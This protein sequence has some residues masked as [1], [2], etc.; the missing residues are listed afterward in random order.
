MGDFEKAVKGTPDIK[1]GF[2]NGLQALGSNSKYV[3]TKDNS[4]IEGSVDIDSST[5]DKYPTASRWDYA[6]G[7]S[8]DVYFIEVHPAASGRNV[9][10]MLAKFNWL[11]SWLSSD[12]PLLNALPNKK[13]RW[14]N[15]GK[16]ALPNSQAVRKLQQAG[17]SLVG[18][19]RM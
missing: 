17:V 16:V 6:V 18:K 19:V 14:V 7:Y 11:K 10:E 15:T 13:F 5:H 9:D 1:D 8:D 2:K 4:L 12:A 3:S